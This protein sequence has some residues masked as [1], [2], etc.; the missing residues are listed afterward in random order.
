MISITV[1]AVVFFL[2]SLNISNLPKNL[3]LNLNGPITGILPVNTVVYS[4]ENFTE[5]FDKITNPQD[6]KP[7]LQD[8]LTE[9][10]SAVTQQAY[11]SCMGDLQ[12]VRNLTHPDV[13]K[14]TVSFI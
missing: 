4:Q 10:L 3:Q 8:V 14:N 6:C 1:K 12:N 9:T 11:L 5:S 2:A 13:G 7:A